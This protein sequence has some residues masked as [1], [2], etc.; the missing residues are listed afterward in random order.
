MPEFIFPKP[1]GSCAVGTKL[2]ELTDATRNDPET[3]KPREMVV[4]VWY[5]AE[6][7]TGEKTALYAYEVRE[8]YKRAFSKDDISAEKIN[9]I[10][11]IRTHALS[12]GPACS[13]HAPYPVVIFGHGFTAP[14]GSYSL[15]C[16]EIAS[17]GYVVVMVMHTYMTSLVRFADGR[18]ISSIRAKKV[19]A[20]LEDCFADIKFIL[21]QAIVGAFGAL[22]TLCDF[23]AIGM[24]GHSLGGIMTAQVCRRDARV[25]AGISLDGTLW[26]I[27]GTV[28][29]HKPF[30]FLR[31]PNF[32]EDMS[33]ILEYQ[34]DLLQAMG[35]TQENF[36]GSIERFCRANGKDTQQ[37]VVRGSTHLTFSDDP[38]LQDFFQ[39]IFN[40]ACDLSALKTNQELPLPEPLKIIR[41]CIITFLDRSLKGKVIPYPAAVQHDSDQEDFDYYVPD[42]H[43]QHVKVEILPTILDDYVG[44]YI[45]GDIIFT[46]T[47]DGNKL[48]TQ[49]ADQERYQI[50]PESETTF[51]F[52][53][54]DIQLTFVKNKDDKVTHLIWHQGSRDQVVERKN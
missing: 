19:C 31:T 8:V 35:I 11:S 21:D 26:G 29:F 5:P 28:P 39:K 50:Y 37:I 24:V 53:A 48:Y 34:K 12:E 2:F 33:G 52:T 41:A 32:Y 1:T 43:P 54:A 49:V 44:Q 14:R 4:Q 17:H 40:P 7:S 25:K 3:N 42:K 36:K 20:V 22:T 38:I 9:L 15:F 13:K 46:V 47:K 18:E 27:N 51:F 45:F 30:L 6:R 10:D 16:E 23:S